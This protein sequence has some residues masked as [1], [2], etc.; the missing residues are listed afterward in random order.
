MNKL[1]IALA[2][3]SIAIALLSLLILLKPY[4]A[5]ITLPPTTS[6]VNVTKTAKPAEEKI[7]WEDLV[8]RLELAIFNATYVLSTPSGNITYIYAQEGGRR[9]LVIATAGDML[10][11]DL[12][13]STTYCSHIG[14]LGAEPSL[15]CVKGNIIGRASIS[16][17]L[18]GLNVTKFSGSLDTKFGR[19]YCYEGSPR[20]GVRT[21]ACLLSSGVPYVVEVSQ[22]AYGMVQKASMELK[23][24]TMEFPEE[25]VEY[26]EKYILTAAR[27]YSA[28]ERLHGIFGVVRVGD[29]KGPVMYYFYDVVCPYCS[30]LHYYNSTVL[31]KFV[32]EGGTLIIVPTLTHLAEYNSTMVEAGEK[33]M[34]CIASLE[35]DKA[36]E[37]LDD[38]FKLAFEGYS[39]YNRTLLSV[40]PQKELELLESKYGKCERPV[41]LT[42]VISAV[43][44]VARLIVV[45]T[46]SG[47]IPTPTL[48]LID[49]RRA[50]YT[51]IVG[52]DPERLAKAVESTE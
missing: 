23:E 28:L 19:A 48:I 33:V 15:A 20:T 51:I 50:N 4:R 46:G 43:G 24:L 18:R 35:P 2:V 12:I 40:L 42:N 21:S 41:N 39:K 36:L 10:R 16:N 49:S 29:L 44:D 1:V 34:G 3:A 31:H 45:Y 9:I 38:I 8:E 22:T 32:E 17:L 5:P 6:P 47:M 7:E 52:Y 13:N 26:Y 37:A 14:L 25:L 27:L 30:M 11:V